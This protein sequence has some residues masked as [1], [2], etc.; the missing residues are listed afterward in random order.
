MENFN[1][2]QGIDPNVEIITGALTI[3]YPTYSVT[4]MNT[5]NANATVQGKP[6]PSGAVWNFGARQGQIYKPNK[7]VLDATGTELTL[8]IN[9]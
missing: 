9:K 3:N 7:F 1:N 5:G 6:M 2:N 8:L 4:V